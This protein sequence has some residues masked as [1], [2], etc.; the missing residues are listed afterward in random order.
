MNQLPPVLTTYI[1]GLKSHDVALITNT[2]AEDLALVL[3]TRTLRKQSF[4]SYLT[5]LY[6]A[7]PDW[8]YQHGEP[9]VRGDGSISIQ[10]SQGGTHTGTWVVAGAPPVSPTRKTV[11]IPLQ[12][13]LYKVAG[14]KITEIRPEPIEGGVPQ[15]VLDQIGVGDLVL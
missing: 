4:L 9:D 8:H 7:F 1:Q 12:Y 6:A 10:F 2:L 14:G 13:F 11:N 15:A 5:A 3:A